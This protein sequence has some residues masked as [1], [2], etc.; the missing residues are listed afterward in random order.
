ML[1]KSTGKVTMVKTVTTGL[2]TYSTCTF[3]VSKFSGRGFCGTSFP[4][5]LP[6]SPDIST[7][8][9]SSLNLN[10]PVVG[11]FAVVLIVSLE[12]MGASKF[13]HDDSRLGTQDDVFKSEMKH[14]SFRSNS[15]D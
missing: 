14:G 13:L 2:P 1:T 6:Q 7:S 5:D 4:F 11:L 8:F 9:F 10:L 12:S 3:G 15:E